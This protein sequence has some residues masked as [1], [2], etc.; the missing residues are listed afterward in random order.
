MNDLNTAKLSGRIDKYDLDIDFTKL[1]YVEAEVH[2]TEYAGGIDENG[3]ERKDNFKDEVNGII[4]Y[5][6]P[7][8]STILIYD[9]VRNLY[10][11][12]IDLSDALEQISEYL[13][14][15]A[16]S[17]D[18]SVFVQPK[19][20]EKQYIDSAALKAKSELD[21][22]RAETNIYFS[23][24]NID[25]SSVEFFAGKYIDEINIENEE[26]FQQYVEENPDGE[27]DIVT[28]YYCW[29]D[30]IGEEAQPASPEQLR[31][32]SEN[33]NTESR[34]ATL[35]GSKEFRIEPEECDEMEV[36]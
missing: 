1:D 20:G 31:I 17:A 5:A 3:H 4:I 7:D 30:K 14:L 35:I 13:D 19:D 23:V 18:V 22:F 21:K 34:N 12:P 16:G 15:S 32:I 2:S 24:V 29:G 9:K 10:D 27:K 25:D 6:A 33:W 11:T 26:A 8:N 36:E 28:D